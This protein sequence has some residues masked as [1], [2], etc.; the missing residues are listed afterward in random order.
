MGSQIFVEKKRINSTYQRQRKEPGAVPSGLKVMK[1]AIDWYA[2]LARIPQKY[3][4]YCESDKTTLT[5]D[6]GTLE[7]LLGNISETVYDNA[8]MIEALKS[9]SDMDFVRGTSKLS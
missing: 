9:T 2:A 7:I 5:A 4:L 8:V 6:D 3:E 1:N